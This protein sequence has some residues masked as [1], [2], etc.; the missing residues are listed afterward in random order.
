MDGLYAIDRQHLPRRPPAELVG[1]VRSADSDRQGVHSCALDEIRRLRGIGEHLLARQLAFGPDT[2]LLSRH[3]GFERPETSELT[4]HRNTNGVRDLG[5][6]RR[7]IHV[8]LIRS[9]SFH[10]L[11][12]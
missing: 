10:I 1:P 7:D 2:I 8:V 12:Q 4:L 3:P 5:N 6:F 9:G 11:P